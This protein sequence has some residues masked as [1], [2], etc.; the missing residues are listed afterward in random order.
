[1]RDYRDYRPKV[2]HAKD[3]ELIVW[4]GCDAHTA[5]IHPGTSA[6]SSVEKSPSVTNQPATQSEAGRLSWT[7]LAASLS[8]L[9][10]HRRTRLSC[11]IHYKSSSTAYSLYEFFMNSFSFTEILQVIRILHSAFPSMKKHSWS[12]FL[13]L[14]KGQSILVLKYCYPY[15]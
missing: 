2:K 1:M 12:V 11:S 10:P 5:P 9:K 3:K 6:T 4:N 14:T 15:L 7:L 13:A 8:F